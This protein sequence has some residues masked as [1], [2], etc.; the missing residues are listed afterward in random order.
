MAKNPTKM[1]FLGYVQNIIKIVN[2]ECKRRY[3]KSV[4]ILLKKSS[5]NKTIHI[6]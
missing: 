3:D 4:D 2:W 1:D 6:H 5:T